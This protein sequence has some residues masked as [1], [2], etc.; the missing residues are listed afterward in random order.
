MFTG[1]ITT[2]GRLEAITDKGDRLL[3]I[4]HGAFFDGLC[5]PRVW[6]GRIILY[7]RSAIGGRDC[8]LDSDAIN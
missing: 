3:R 2:I 1:I 7:S 6:V 4:F 5:I 8:D